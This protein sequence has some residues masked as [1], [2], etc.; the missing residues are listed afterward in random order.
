MH[1]MTWNDLPSIHDV[2]DIDEADERCLDEIKTVLERHD[3]VNRFG[4]A[5][6]HQHFKLSDEELLVEHCDVEGRTLTT[7]PATEKDFILRHY[8]PTVWRF[9]GG[10]AQACAYCP[11]HGVNGGLELRRNGGENCA[12]RRGVTSLGGQGLLPVAAAG[13]GV[14]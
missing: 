6:L 10:R 11:K 7:R 9:D 5:L 14:A 12:L 1:P 2:G 8:L 4:V 3:K 13:G